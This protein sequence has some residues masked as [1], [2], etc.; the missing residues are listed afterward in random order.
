METAVT[1]L[2]VKRDG[3]V[4]P[5]GTELELEKDEFEEL[6][7]EGV[8]DGS[9]SGDGDDGPTPEKLKTRLAQLIKEGAD[10]EGLN[11]QKTKAALGEGFD[12]VKRVEVDAALAELKNQTTE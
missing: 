7:A 10:F 1:K 5:T 9:A 11:M 2:P 6:K 8:I 4:L 12:H 3:K